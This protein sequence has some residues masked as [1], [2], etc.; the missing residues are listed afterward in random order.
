MNEP[1]GV[2][3]NLKA[4][5]MR[6]LEE[7]FARL[8]SLPGRA[9]Y[10]STKQADRYA[11]IDSTGAVEYHAESEMDEVIRKAEGEA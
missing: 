1:V 8:F 5:R 3:S 11:S 4:A 2:S 7:G 10:G 6:L 9:V